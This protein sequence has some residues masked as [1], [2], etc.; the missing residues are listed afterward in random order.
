VAIGR[1]GGD[2]PEVAGLGSRG[3]GRLRGRALELCDPAL[4]LGDAVELRLL[5]GV[6]TTATRHVGGGRRADHERGTA[7]GAPCGEAA[8]SG[9]TVRQASEGCGAARDRHHPRPLPLV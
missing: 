4:E 3:G 9:A 5:G 1:R 7:Q 2:R 6:A 8:R